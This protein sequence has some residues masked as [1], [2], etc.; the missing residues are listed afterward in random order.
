MVN[1]NE[2]S[3]HQEENTIFTQSSFFLRFGNDASLPSPQEVRTKARAMHPH[4]EMV[5]R[6]AP[7]IYR[8]LG[9]LVKFG[10]E[11]ATAEGQTLVMIRKLLS[12]A[13][14]VPE[15]FAWTQDQGQ[16]FIYMEW[17]DGVTL[18]EAWPSLSEEHRTSLCRGLRSMVNAWKSLEQTSSRPFI[19]T[20]GRQLKQ[21]C[22]MYYRTCWRTASL[23]YCVQKNLL[24]N[25]WSI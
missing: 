17:I 14:P 21:N 23:G 16:S 4:R 3:L 13:V 24:A 18:E 22:L 5:Q 1:S 20:V 6:P 25:S 7:V 11:V 10:T 8:E 15:V 9:L 12:S 2:E 19:G